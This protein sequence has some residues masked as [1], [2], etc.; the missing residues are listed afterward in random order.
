MS[1]CEA[2]DLFDNVNIGD[3]IE[4]MFKLDK[5]QPTDRIMLNTGVHHHSS[6]MNET[7]AQN[8]R[9]VPWWRSNHGQC[10]VW[11]ETLPQHFPNS[12]TGAFEGA[13][14]PCDPAA[15]KSKDPCAPIPHAALHLDQ[16]YNVPAEAALH[17][18]ARA[19]GLKGPVQ[20]ARTYHPLL[21]R[22]GDHGASDS[23]TP[24]VHRNGQYRLDCTHYQRG[25]S[26]LVMATCLTLKE[27]AACPSPASSLTL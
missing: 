15:P 3:A 4:C 11:R 20:I 5:L 25:S 24:C 10:L 1:S 12:S 26:A 14:M 22:H 18:A 13:F 23:D 16:G 27:L 2:I 17:D 8:V 6:R 21:D 7:I 19:Q 9:A